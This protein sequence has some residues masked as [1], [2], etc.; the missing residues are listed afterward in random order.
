MPGGEYSAL[1]GLLTRLDEL[2]RIAGDL[3]N[4]NKPLQVSLRLHS[5]RNG[6]EASRAKP[7][8]HYCRLCPREKWLNGA[9][10]V[11]YLRRKKYPPLSV[12]RR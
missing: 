9:K 10:V 3:A 2:D 4:V 8:K 5:L 12:G 7:T 6:K 1:S 11:G